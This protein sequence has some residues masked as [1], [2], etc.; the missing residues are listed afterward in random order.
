MKA[1]IFGALNWHKLGESSN[2]NTVRSTNAFAENFNNSLTK[3][4]DI[5]S[6]LNPSINM[7]NHEPLICQNGNEFAYVYKHWWFYKE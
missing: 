1:S 4:V 6:L 5:F 7:N 3:K 2:L